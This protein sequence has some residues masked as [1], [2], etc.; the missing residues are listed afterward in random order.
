MDSS[1]LTIGGEGDNGGDGD[2]GIDCDNAVDEDD[3]ERENRLGE[4]A[5]KA[6]GDFA[7]TVAGE[8]PDDKGWARSRLLEDDTVVL[9]KLTQVPNFE[10]RHD[11]QCRPL[12]THEQHWH[13][14]FLAQQQH[15]RDEPPDAMYRFMFCLF[16]SQ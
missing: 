8:E 15:W 5:D 12:L 11:I 1:E 3:W 14:P 6:T 9:G 16:S 7:L 4:Q 10:G 2:N 13:W